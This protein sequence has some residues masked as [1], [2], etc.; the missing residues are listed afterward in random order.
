MVS[1]GFDESAAAGAAG[2][3]YDDHFPAVK[4]TVHGFLKHHPELKLH[5]MNGTGS[6]W[7]EWGSWY[8]IKEK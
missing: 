1:Y 2:H 6:T 5:T 3:D 4:E 8:V 7:D